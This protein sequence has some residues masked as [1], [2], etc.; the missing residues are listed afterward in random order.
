MMVTLQS[1]WEQKSTLANLKTI[2]LFHLNF[3]GHVQQ[4][5]QKRTVLF[6]SWVPYLVKMYFGF[7][8]LYK[9]G[10]LVS[11]DASIWKETKLFYSSFSK[12]F[13]TSGL[14]FQL[15]NSRRCSFSVKL[16]HSM[17]VKTFTFRYVLRS[18][19][20]VAWNVFCQQR[21]PLR[22]IFLAV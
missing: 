4:I 5:L 11:A 12:Y 19:K 1:G 15:S 6:T 22:F 16:S 8:R 2:L 7:H 18:G 21:R 10:I 20:I 17:L 3:R 9:T 14:K 13:Q